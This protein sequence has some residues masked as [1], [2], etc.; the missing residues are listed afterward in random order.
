MQLENKPFMDYIREL[1][2]V[3]NVLLTPED[4]EIEPDKTGAARS[5]IPVRMVCEKLG[6]EVEYIPETKE[7]VVIELPE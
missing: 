6:K 5:W 2:G 1:I 3:K 4:Y 7:I